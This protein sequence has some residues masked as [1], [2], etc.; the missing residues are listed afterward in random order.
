MKFK[1]LFTVIA[2][3]IIFSVNS[4]F[5]DNMTEAKLQYNKGIDYYKIGQYDRSMEAFRRAIEL[6]PEYIDAYYNLGSILEYLGQDEA[7][8]TVFKQIVVRKPTDYDAV[9][10]AAELSNKLGQTDK[11]KSFLAIIPSGSYVNPKAQKLANEL[12]TDLQTIKYEQNT[13]EQPTQPQNNGVYENIPS[14]TGITTDKSGNLFVAGFSDNVIFKITP[15]GDR[16][17]FLKDKRLNGP[18]GIINDAEGNLYIANYNADNV[19]KVSSTGQ[20]TVL[21]EDILKP[22]GVY[23]SNGTLFVSSQGSNA[24]IRYKL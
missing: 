5:A 13:T 3:S 24:I 14:P 20:V 18:I 11:A 1:N 21:I 4:G 12:N 19:L 7:A 10:K 8:L 2:L 16:I 15:Q 23:I 9:Y 22:Y 17:V 6:D